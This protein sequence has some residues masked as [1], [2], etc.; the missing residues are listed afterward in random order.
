MPSYK[1]SNPCFPGTLYKKKEEKEKKDYIMFITGLAIGTL[2]GIV[3][4][5]SFG[6]FQMEK[7]SRRLKDITF[8]D[9]D[10]NQYKP[11]VRPKIKKYLK[12]NSS[13]NIANNNGYRYVDR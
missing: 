4:G 6:W 11:Y 12:Q 5:G 7:L 9:R 13:T 2:I 10:I 3:V 8:K 1:V